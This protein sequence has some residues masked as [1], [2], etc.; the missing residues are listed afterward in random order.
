VEPTVTEIAPQ[1]YRVSTYV[2]G[3]GLV[4]NQFVVDSEEPLLFH[5]G[6]RAL[7]PM[8]STA[9]ERVVSV[10]RL[11]W[12]TFGHLE[13]DECGAMNAWLAAAPRSQ[14][15][16]GAL[17]CAVSVNDLADRPPRPLTDGEVL[18]LGGRR[19]RRLETPH[20]PHGW[21]AGLYFEE[22]TGTLM[23]GD[24]FTALGDGQ[25]LTDH[26]IVG[27]A[28]AAE[29]VFH[30]TCL[31]PNTGPAIRALADLSPS[32]LALMH[33]PA[34]TGDGARALR[35]LAD[36]YDQRLAQDSARD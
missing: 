1:I 12:I 32:M 31:T 34:Y 27:P 19:L 28:F 8:V 16:H 30:A 29:D 21:D 10:E 22:V 14:I 25:A 7:F 15:A 18:D 5:T 13:A 23:A 2:P 36:G 9:V 11:R 26:D 24:L 4:F 20:V 17:G 35:D 3:P 33:G 6:P